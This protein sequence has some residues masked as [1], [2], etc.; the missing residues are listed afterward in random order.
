MTPGTDA[1]NAQA[2]S[3]QAQLLEGLGLQ[4]LAG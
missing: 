1:I 3:I 2:N 4:Q